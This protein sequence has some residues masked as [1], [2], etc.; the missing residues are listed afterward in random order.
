MSLDTTSGI[1]LTSALEDYLETIFQFN[2][3]FGFVRVRDIAKARNVKAGSV[4]PAMKRLSKMGLIEYERRE[5]IKLTEKGEIFARAIFS[6]HEVLFRFFKEVLKMDEHEASTNAC[7]MEHSLSDA[8][9]NHFVFFMEYHLNCPNAKMEYWNRFF[10][11][12]NGII[13]QDHQESCPD[14]CGFFYGGKKSTRQR[15]SEMTPG[16][17]AVVLRIDGNVESRKELLQKGVL[18]GCKISIDHYHSG[19]E[20]V[21][22][23]IDDFKLKLLSSKAPLII[24]S[25]APQDS[26][27]S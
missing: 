23:I 12:Q 11:C 1:K 3:K 17:E 24:V 19:G 27:S 26:I 8:A 25:K 7:S 20:F 13:A 6:R 5:Y 14:S 21:I 16:E 4:S 22:L 10:D 2:Q 18:P 9:M 15:L